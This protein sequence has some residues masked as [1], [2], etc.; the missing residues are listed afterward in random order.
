MTNSHDP[1]RR[2][3]ETM[4]VEQLKT[5]L[6]VTEKGLQQQTTPDSRVVIIEAARMT[7]AAIDRKFLEIFE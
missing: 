5:A 4:T 2:M 7:E 6:A 1:M 3:L